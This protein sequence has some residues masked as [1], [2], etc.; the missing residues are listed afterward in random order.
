LFAEPTTCSAAAQQRL[1][2]A[3]EQDDLS[4]ELCFVAPMNCS[5]LFGRINLGTA[6]LA[7]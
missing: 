2:L 4:L 1:Y 6:L 5:C 3:L 7:G